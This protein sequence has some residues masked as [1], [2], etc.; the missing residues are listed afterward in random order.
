MTEVNQIEIPGSADITMVAVFHDTLKEALDAGAP[1]TFNAATVTRADTA[2]LQLLT[3][4][5]IDASTKN[6]S[7]TWSSMSEAFEQA[8][9][10]LGLTEYFK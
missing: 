7:V 5:Q 9:K 1:V 2:F 10:L 6:I 8:V 3:S 4:F